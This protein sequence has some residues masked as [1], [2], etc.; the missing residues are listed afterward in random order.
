MFGGD[1]KESAVVGPMSVKRWL[2]LL[3]GMLVC[4]Q[5]RYD[6]NVRM[7]TYGHFVLALPL[8]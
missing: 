7:V 2:V 6:I 1:L 3:A 8:R 4:W 5:K